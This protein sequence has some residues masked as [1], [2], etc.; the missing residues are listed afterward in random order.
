MKACSSQQ[1]SLRGRSNGCGGKGRF[2][3][4]ILLPRNL[5]SLSRP[6]RIT[7]VLK[8]VGLKLCLN[9]MDVTRHAD[10]MS[11]KFSGEVS[12]QEG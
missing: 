2:R 5:N 12:V 3:A 10:G 9:K 6:Q 11:E 7:E 1:S 4:L 8:V